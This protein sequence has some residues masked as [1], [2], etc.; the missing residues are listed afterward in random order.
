MKS[1]IRF[2]LFLAVFIMVPLFAPAQ[3]Q[4]SV[5]IRIVQDRS[6]VLHDFETHLLLK[7]KKFSIQ[8]LLQN[9]RGVYVFASVLDSVYRFSATDSIRDF[10]YL[11]MLELKEDR[12]N[13]EKALNISETGWS[14][15][16]YE[17]GKEHPF[18][19][20]VHD[21]DDNRIIATKFVKYLYNVGEGKQVRVKDVKGP[22][23]LFFIAVEEYDKDG[24][25]M[26]ELLRRKVKI[27]WINDDYDDDDDDD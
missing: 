7:K 20:K 15:W 3:D 27:E 17:A 26:K 1:I 2:R 18:Y 6:S 9:I 5:M 23:Y 21:L 14:N 13:T 10:I 4:K 16:F 22:L 12:Y 24:K 11:P 19:F 8:V 25:P